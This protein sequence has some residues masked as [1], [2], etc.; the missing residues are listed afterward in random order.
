MTSIE[1]IKDTAEEALERGEFQAAVTA[2][3]ALVEAGEPWLLDGLVRRAMALENWVEGPPDRLSM[4][5]ND[6]RKMVEIAPASI[7]YCGLARVLLKL[8][9]RDSAYIN[10]L[11]AER[12]GVT[13]EVFL[14]SQNIIQPPHP[15]TLS[16]QRSIS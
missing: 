7:S 3:S 11:E 2:A 1:A 12:R 8:G 6:W 15:Q 9:D 10:L 13:P 16:R 4:A 14:G 5:A